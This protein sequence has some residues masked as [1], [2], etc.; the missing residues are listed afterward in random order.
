MGWVSDVLNLLNMKIAAN[1]QSKR[2]LSVKIPIPHIQDHGVLFQ[3][4]R[5]GF[6]WW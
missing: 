2:K 1:R 3:T 4:C 5:T 6:V